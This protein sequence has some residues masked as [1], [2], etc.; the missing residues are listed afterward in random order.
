MLTDRG[1]ICVSVHWSAGT[2]RIGVWAS[3]T[4]SVKDKCPDTVLAFM[5]LCG[6]TNRDVRSFVHLRGRVL[7]SMFRIW[8]T[9][10]I[11]HTSF[12]IR[13]SMD[14]WSR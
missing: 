12:L 10:V 9:K 7:K 3:D 1:I 4:A 5:R 13:P 6:V 8:N 14:R 11:L 2:R